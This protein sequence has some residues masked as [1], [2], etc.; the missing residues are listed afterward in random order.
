MPP[1]I[2]SELI[3][4]LLHFFY[5]VILT[6]TFSL[7]FCFSLYIYICKFL[8]DS[9]IIASM[10]VIYINIYHILE[11]IARPL[12]ELSL[13]MSINNFKTFK[14]ISF[15]VNTIDKLLL[16]FQ[17]DFKKI[18]TIITKLFV[19]CSTAHFVYCIAPGFIIKTPG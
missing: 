4:Y 16:E 8:Q 18:P 13:M 1:I 5:F 17:V 3:R 12:I 6:I 10:N 11:E 14:K 7:T 2:K 19:I 15:L 9:S